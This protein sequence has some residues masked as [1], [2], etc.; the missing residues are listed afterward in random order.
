M[1][2]SGTGFVTPSQKFADY[3]PAQS[4]TPIQGLK[5]YGRDIY[6]V[7]L[8]AALSGTGFVTP[9]QKFADYLPAQS[10]TPIQ[11][12]KPY[13]RDANPVRLQAAL[14]GTGFVTSSQKFADYPL[15][16]KALHQSKASNL[17]D[18]MHIPSG[19]KPLQCPSFPRN[20]DSCAR[21]QA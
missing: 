2:L 7:R 21:N 6:P 15:L 17:T 5:H 3:L 4:I 10:I 1:L 16:R 14:S 18:G 13:G 19:S 20:S 11:G 12:L 8:Q 9:S